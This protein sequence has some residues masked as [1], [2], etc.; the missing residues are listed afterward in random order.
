[1]PRHKA[2]CYGCD[3]RARIGFMFCSQRCAAAYAENLLDN[4]DTSYCPTC[5][6]WETVRYNADQL[7]TC[8]H[9]GTGK[10]GAA[11]TERSY[12]ST[13]GNA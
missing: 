6:T 8:G 13:V 10:T 11:C 9:T 4:A 3:R 1:M 2:K 12:S 7:L 5:G